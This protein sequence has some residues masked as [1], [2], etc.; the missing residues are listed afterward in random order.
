ME[1][2]HLV[3]H[4]AVGDQSFEPTSAIARLLVRE[5]QRAEDRA[6]IALAVRPAAKPRLAAG[7][8]A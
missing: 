6:E 7:S 2:G 4:F 1:N 5:R 3:E 8:G